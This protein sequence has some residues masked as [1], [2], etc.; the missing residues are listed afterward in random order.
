ML[1]ISKLKQLIF[2]ALLAA[3]AMVLMH[4]GTSLIPA[5]R[6]LKYEPS[7]AIILLCGM[8]LGPAAAAE[9]A[10]VKCILY[11]ISHGGNPYGHLSDLIAMLTFAC[12]AAA[13][14]HRMGV[15]SGKKRILA[16]AVGVLTVTLVMIPANYVILYLQYGMTPAAVTA[17]MIYVI[18]YNILK[19]ALNS[20]LALVV[21]TPVYKA[22]SKMEVS[23]S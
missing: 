14:M 6:Y 15:Q 10:L 2:V 13:L 4:T 22:L 16:C 19:A 12:I 3:M 7:G 21:Y 20:V 18:P 17:T 23:H 8:L 9:C 5:A 1:K 11:F